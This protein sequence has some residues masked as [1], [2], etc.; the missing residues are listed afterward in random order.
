MKKRKTASYTA[1]LLLTPFLLLAG[2][3]SNYPAR[4]KIHT[5]PEGAHVIYREGASE[6]IY[7]GSTPL[8][9]TRSIHKDLPDDAPIALRAMRNGYLDQTKKWRN[10]QLEE[11][12]DEKQLILWTPRLIK[13]AE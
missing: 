7:L 13:N 5:D 12:M 3:A 9:V 10:E 6:W 2:C 1:L 11:E 8:E 4:F